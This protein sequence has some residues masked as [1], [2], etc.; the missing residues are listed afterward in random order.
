M[1]QIFT[2]FL[3]WLGNKCLLLVA[4]LGLLV[5]LAWLRGAWNAAEETLWTTVRLEKAV[6]EMAEKRLE[7]EGKIRALGPNV[8]AA[9]LKL[10]DL[11]AAAI[12]AQAEE[13]R[14]RR[15]YDDLLA[16]FG[17]W[18]KMFQPEKVRDV[19][20]A[21]LDWET[22]KQWARAAVLAAKQQR[23]L[24]E[25][26][27]W[28]QYAEELAQHSVESD[29]ATNAYHTAMVASRDKPIARVVLAVRREL[30]TAL[31]V[32]ASVVFLPIGIKCLC[33]F[34]IAPLAK[35]LRPVRLLPG[36]TVCPSATASA[37]SHSLEIKPS[38][39]LLV[40]HQFLQSVGTAVRKR[41]RWLLNPAMPFSSLAAGMF[42]LTAV[43]CSGSQT[44]RATVSPLADPLAEIALIEI[45]AG[46]AMVIQPRAMVGVVIEIGQAMP[47]TSHWRLGHGH[48]WVTFQFRYIV[49]H[50]PCK[51]LVKG[52]R[53][54]R[55][56]CPEAGQARLLNQNATIGFSANLAYSTTRCETFWAYFSGKEDLFNDQFSGEFGMYLYEE[57][58][59]AKRRSG[60]TG[61]G[62]EGVIDAALKA[63]GI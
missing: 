36:P 30:G 16:Q 57:M 37:V 59:G 5:A 2:D 20:Q 32:L 51:L 8:E 14:A 47:I 23:T 56:E 50:G 21:R 13:A 38:E 27:L 11:E 3:R 34:G 28:G 54:V 52:C 25:V 24:E 53:G 42:G 6:Y 63:F 19:A 43:R 22:K 39:E 4:I 58:P 7:I 61:R 12:K 45:P 41:T 18:Q 33:Y 40:R 55:A 29:K 60:L 48:A 46:A 17:W 1:T 62:L 31:W 35:H 26:K 49:L 15:H 44:E 10:R 9:L